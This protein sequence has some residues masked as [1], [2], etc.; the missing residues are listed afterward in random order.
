MKKIRHI[1]WF[2]LLL[3]GCK[4]NGPGT[5]ADIKAIA[6]QPI[7]PFS[8]LDYIRKEVGAFF[9][10]PVIML[11]PIGMP[12]GALDTSKGE[13]YSAD[14][15]L[16]HLASGAGDHL[17]LIVALTQQDIYTTV[18][19]NNGAIKSPAYKYAVWGIFGLGDCPGAASIVSDHRLR[20][21]DTAQ[22]HHRLRSVVLHELGHNFGL[23]HCPNPRCIMNDANE[24][25]ATIDNS[26][27]DYCPACRKKLGLP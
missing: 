23:P 6:L 11:P 26:A 10:K 13:R 18:R 9:H 8:E 17:P 25:I 14:S 27:N 12:P 7:G 4:S 1:G 24:K 21:T 22:Y 19:D 5:P 2:L 15:I 20:T 3:A 16:H